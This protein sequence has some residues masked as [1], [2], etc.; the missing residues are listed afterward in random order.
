MY[1]Q[2]VQVDLKLSSSKCE[3]LFPESRISMFR[4]ELSIVSEKGV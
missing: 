4:H 1:V 2:T 3:M